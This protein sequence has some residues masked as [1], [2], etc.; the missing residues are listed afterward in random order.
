MGNLLSE[1]A[2]DDI[3]LLSIIVKCNDLSTDKGHPFLVIK[4][5]EV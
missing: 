2:V 3:G 5:I 1:Y 4:S